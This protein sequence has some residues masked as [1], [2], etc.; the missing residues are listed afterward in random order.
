MYIFYYIY[1]LYLYN[2][3]YTVN[4]TKIQFFFKSWIFYN[5]CNIDLINSFLQIERYIVELLLYIYRESFLFTKF[6][7]PILDDNID[8]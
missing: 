1:K 2:Y 8:Y 5:K 6:L 3:I 7:I 4:N